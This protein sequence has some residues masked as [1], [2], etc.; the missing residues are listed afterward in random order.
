M[1]KALGAVLV[2][3]LVAALPLSGTSLQAQET[4]EI[5]VEVSQEPVQ[6]AAQDMADYSYADGTIVEVSGTSLVLKENDYMTGEEKDQAYVISP[7]VELSEITSIGDLKAGDE[8]FVEYKEEGG[9]K[10]VTYMSA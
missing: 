10:T 2:A 4:E 8:V 3:F 5:V 6:E 1:K 7:D 9:Q